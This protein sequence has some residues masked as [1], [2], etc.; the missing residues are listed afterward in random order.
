VHRT[1]AG[2]PARH[3]ASLSGVL[4]T[5]NQLAIVTGIAAA[6]TLYLSAGQAT[7]LPPMSVVL[8]ALATALV[9]AGTGVSVALARARRGEIAHDRA[10]R[11]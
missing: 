9:V 5:I 2:V 11:S 8:F 3:A 6:G 7:A 1:T 10:P 4:A